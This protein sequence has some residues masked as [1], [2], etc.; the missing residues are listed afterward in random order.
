MAIKTKQQ[1]EMDRTIEQTYYKYASGKQINIMKIGMLYA[2]AR[3]M[4]SKGM[5][6]EE[7]FPA[8]IEKYCEKV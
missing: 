3:E 5:A 1:K 8:L 7:F 4:I 2:E 6:I